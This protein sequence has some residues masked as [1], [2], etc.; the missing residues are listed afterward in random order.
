MM[1]KRI[2]YWISTLVVPVI[3]VLLIVRLLLTPLYIQVEY[4]T[5]RFSGRFLWFFYG[6]T[7]VLG[8]YFEIIFG[9]Q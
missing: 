9:E 8:K 1:I 6:R 4:R 7:V 2:L 3:L 5:A